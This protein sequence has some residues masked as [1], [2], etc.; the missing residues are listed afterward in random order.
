MIFPYWEI[1]LDSEI[2]WLPLLPV[3]IHGQDTSV[4]VLALV[5]SGSEYTVLGLDL[6]DRLEISLTQSKPAI[7]VGLGEHEEPGEMVP[8]NFQV[9]KYRWT[10]PAV[11]SA[12]ASRRA[13]LGQTGF[14]AFFAVAFRYW[15]REMDI[16]RRR[17]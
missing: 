8:V 3:T 1:R 14:F 10:G 15:K 12:A 6:V 5:D 7:L 9:G 16:R 17:S 4:D 2:H 13:I 11:F